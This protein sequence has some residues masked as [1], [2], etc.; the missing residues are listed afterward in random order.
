MSGANPGYILP[1]GGYSDWE[2]V[3]AEQPGELT[4][5]VDQV[6]EQLDVAF[7]VLDADQHD[8]SGWLVPGRKGGDTVGKVKIEKPGWYW[9]QYADANNDGRSPM[10]F[11]IKREFTAAAPPSP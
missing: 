5:T 3:Y 1:I 10:P 8:L 11:R 9:I 7:H 6:P 2:V 4:V